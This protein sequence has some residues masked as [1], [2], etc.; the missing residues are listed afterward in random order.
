MIPLLLLFAVSVSAHDLC[1]NEDS[2][3]QIE[4]PATEDEM[5]VQKDFILH[6]HLLQLTRRPTNFTVSCYVPRIANVY[7]LTTMEGTDR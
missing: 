1:T 5:R 6:S 2:C 3:E 4:I 7:R